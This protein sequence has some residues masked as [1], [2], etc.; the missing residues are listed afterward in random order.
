M[1]IDPVLVLI[2]T[3][4]VFANMRPFL[5]DIFKCPPAHFTGRAL[6]VQLG[7]FKTFA[8]FDHINY[9]QLIFRT[10]KLIE[11]RKTCNHYSQTSLKITNYF[12]YSWSSSRYL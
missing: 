2:D 12:I 4:A 1:G 6:P 5:A 3:F 7:H 11:N 10:D 8:F 9:Y